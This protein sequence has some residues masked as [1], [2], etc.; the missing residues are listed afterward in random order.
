M[1][2]FTPLLCDLQSSYRSTKTSP[3]R[4]EVEARM[5]M[6]WR[7]GTS[8]GIVGWPYDVSLVGTNTVWTLKLEPKPTTL[9][10]RAWFAFAFWDF[11]PQARTTYQM[12]SRTM[13][14]TGSGKSISGRDYSYACPAYFD[15]EKSE[16][17]TTNDSGK[18]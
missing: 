16:D 4:E 13:T 1:G 17:P 14:Y 7:I 3:T 2:R 12:D 15:F 9:W 10:R 8:W 6:G 18:R 5:G 11:D